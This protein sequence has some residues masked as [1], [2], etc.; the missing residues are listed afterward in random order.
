MQ[1]MAPQKLATCLAYR[2]TY[3]DR[4]T[5]LIY[6]LIVAVHYGSYLRADKYLYKLYKVVNWPFNLHTFFV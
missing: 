3:V 4:L 2:Y 6:L 1:H 5:I